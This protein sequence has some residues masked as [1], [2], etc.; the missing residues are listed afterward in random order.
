MTL[1]TVL[2]PTILIIIGLSLIKYDRNREMKNKTVIWMSKNIFRDDNGINDSAERL[3]QTI[4]SFI[5]IFCVA[6][7]SLFIIGLYEQWS[8]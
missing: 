4:I 1:L 6:I 2:I 7:S 3:H 5:F 8:I